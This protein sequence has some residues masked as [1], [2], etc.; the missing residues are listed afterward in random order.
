MVGNDE[1]ESAFQTKVIALIKSKGGY[2]LKTHVSSFQRQG[3]PDVT[4]CYK[5]RYLAFELKVKGN[6]PTKLQEHKMCEIRRAGG[7]AMVARTL[8]EVEEALDEISGVQQGGK[9]Q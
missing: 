4:V 3:E 9:S 7:I 1:L 6:K 8:K 5:G 2:V